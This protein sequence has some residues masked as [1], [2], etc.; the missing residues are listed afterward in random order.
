M[1][2]VVLEKHYNDITSNLK[3]NFKYLLTSTFGGIML[4]RMLT[5]SSFY[6]N[7]FLVRLPL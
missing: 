7:Y 1:K 3:K 5:K 6:P 2:E 4:N